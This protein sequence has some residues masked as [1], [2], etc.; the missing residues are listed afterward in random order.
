[1]GLFP[2]IEMNSISVRLEQ[3]IEGLYYFLP[4]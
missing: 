1:M 3:L 4:H 2:F